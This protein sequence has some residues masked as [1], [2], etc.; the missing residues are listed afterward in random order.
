MATTIGKVWVEV[1]YR[2]GDEAHDII[3][4]IYDDDKNIDGIVDENLAVTRICEEDVAYCIK[5]GDIPGKTLYTVNGDDGIPLYAIS[6]GDAQV[7]IWK[8]YDMKID[9]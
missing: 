7:T 3:D 1:L 4:A 9:V 8:A 5:T 6:A 2:Q